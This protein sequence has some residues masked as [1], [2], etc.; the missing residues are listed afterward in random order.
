MEAGAEPDLVDENGDTI[1]H[2]KVSI[3]YV[4]FII[5]FDPPVSSPLSHTLS[6]QVRNWKRLVY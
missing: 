3:T 1:S 6:D 5:L 2:T 4:P